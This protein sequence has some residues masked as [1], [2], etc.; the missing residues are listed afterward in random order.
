MYYRVEVNAAVDVIVNVLGEPEIFGGNEAVR[1]GRMEV[2][3][4][5]SSHCSIFTL[6]DSL[7]QLLWLRTSGSIG[8]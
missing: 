4:A 1:R 6:T 2:V 5:I 7:W 3:V 8:R